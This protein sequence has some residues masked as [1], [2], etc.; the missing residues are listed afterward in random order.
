MHV[1]VGEFCMDGS[2]TSD[3]AIIPCI[4]TSI[5]VLLT[6]M[7]STYVFH[8]DLESIKENSPRKKQKDQGRDELAG[9]LTT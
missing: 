8:I 2:R 7:C 1:A 5:R 9:P 4:G 3:D 6:A